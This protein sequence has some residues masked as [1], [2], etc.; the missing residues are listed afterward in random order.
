MDSVQQRMRENIFCNMSKFSSYQSFSFD[1]RPDQYY[2]QPRMTIASLAFFILF[3][4]KKHSYKRRIQ[5]EA[6]AEQLWF[7][8]DSKRRGYCNYHL[9][10][11]WKNCV[12]YQHSVFVCHERLPPQKYII[13][14]KIVNELVFIMGIWCLLWG[15]NWIYKHL[16]HQR[17][18]N[19]GCHVA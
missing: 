13:P 7:I 18:T 2:G 19:I 5:Q 11:H 8:N 1:T 16:I 6:N 3:F 15:A 4:A 10:W 12:F 9:H 17:C 14:L